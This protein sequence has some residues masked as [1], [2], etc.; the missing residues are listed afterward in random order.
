MKNILL[1]M[2]DQQRYDTIAALGNPLIK[3]PQMDRMVHEGVSFERAYSPC[4]VCVPARFSMKTGTLPQRNGCVMNTP[5]PMGYKSL[6]EHLRDAGYQTHGVGKTHF[7]FPQ[8]PDFDWKWGFERFER[9]DTPGDC[10]HRAYLDEKGFDWVKYPAGMRNDFYYIPGQ[11]AMPEH[12]THT[13]WVGDRCVEFLKNRDKSRPFFL[14]AGYFAPHPPFVAPWPWNML[15][16]GGEMPLPRHA[17]NEDYLSTYYTRLQNRYKGRDQGWDDNL[18]AAI[19]AIYYGTISQVDSSVGQILAQMDAE[20]LW[21]DTLVIY[22]SDHGELLGD[23]GMFGKRS[24]LDGAARVP[25]LI[26]YP[27]AQAGQRV[28]TPASLVDI[29]E[30]CLAFAGISGVPSDGVDLRSIADGNCQRR[31]VTGQVGEHGIGS[32]MLADERYKYIYSASDDR[33]Y[34]FDGKLDP[35]ESHNVAHNPAYSLKAKEMRRELVRRLREEG[36][37]DDLNADGTDFRQFP[38][39]DIPEDPEA[40]R[41]EFGE[42]P[43]IPGYERPD[44]VSRMHDLGVPV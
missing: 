14:M 30:T 9:A 3:T 34:L 2:T 24:F 13:H 35:Q 37:A 8:D 17:L 4:P 12:M 11:S 31:A 5:M 10:E 27:G 42:V 23:Y 19:R 20:D 16:R 32:W 25:M 33:E 38:K 44:A 22:T 28:D 1:I 29:F 36:G 15:Y 18:V 41:L 43:L 26:C 39:R 7:F 21:K 6:M 40:W